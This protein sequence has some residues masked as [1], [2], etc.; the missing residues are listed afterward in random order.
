MSTNDMLNM[1]E[2]PKDEKDHL[3]TNDPFYVNTDLIPQASF[4]EQESELQDMGLSVFNQ[5]DFEQGIMDQV[6]RALAKEEENRFRKILQKELKTIGD[7]IVLAKADLKHV[8]EVVDR[9]E[10]TPGHA[11]DRQIQSLQKQKENKLKQIKTLK[12]RHENVTKKLDMLIKGVQIVNRTNN[13]GNTTL[14]EAFSVGTRPESEKERLIRSGEMTPF[15]TVVKPS[16]SAS[17][18]KDVGVPQM[19]AFEKTL[20][21]KQSTSQSTQKRF[22]KY[23]KKKSLE[24]IVRPGLS[25]PP[26]DSEAV[27]QDQSHRQALRRGCKKKTNSESQKEHILSDDLT[28]EED[29]SLNH[30]DEDDY[31]PSEEESSEENFSEKSADEADILSTHKRKRRSSSHSAVRKKPRPLPKYKKNEDDDLAHPKVKRD[32]SIKRE[33]DDADPDYYQKRLRKLQKQEKKGEQRDTDDRDKESEFDGGFHVPQKLWTKLFPYQKTGVRWLWEL[34]CQQ[35]GGI[36][37]D[38]MGLGKTIQTI[39]FLAAL[40]TS[41]LK[42]VNFPYK[43]LGPTI[44][45]CPTTVMHQWLKE[46]HKWW[47]EFRVAILHSSGSFSGSESDLVRSIAKS[48]GILITSYNTLVVHQE[49][50]LRFNWHYVILDEGHKIRNPDAKVTIC[51]KQFRT[52]HRIILSGSPIQN[53]LKELWSLFDFVFPGKL[54]TLP[55]FMQHFSIPIVQGGYSNATQIQVETAYRCACVLRDT[56][57]PYLI[58]RMKADVKKGLDLPNKNEQVLFCRLTDEQREV[59]QEYLASRQ[60]QDILQG[61][62]Q[63][64]VGLITLRKICNHPDLSTGGPQVFKSQSALSDPE[65]QFGYHKRS[66]KMIVVEAL[67]RL[68]YKQQHRVLLFTQSKSM[69]NIL[70]KFVQ[71]QGYSYLIMDGGTSISARQPLITQYNNDPSIYLFLLTTRVG[72]LGVNLTGADR[73]IIY[74]PDWNP[75]TDVQA[76]ERAWR[77]GQTRQVTIYRLLTSGTIEE[78]IYHR[79]VIQIFKQFLTN[80]ILK[81]PKQRRLFKSQDMMELFTLGS[82]DNIEGTET[83]ALFAG[84]GSDVKIPKRRNRNRFDEL[85]EKKEKDKALENVKQSVCEDEDMG[86]DIDELERMKELA[87]QLSRQMENEKKNKLKMADAAKISLDNVQVANVNSSSKATWSSDGSVLNDEH[88]PSSKGCDIN[89]ET[90]VKVMEIEVNSEVNN[91]NSNQPQ[92]VD[93]HQLEQSTEPQWDSIINKSHH[94]L[95]QPTLTQ[96]DNTNKSHQLLD[97]PTLTQSDNT[98]KSH[99]L[100]DQPTLIQSDNT[101]K[102]NQLLDQPTLTQSDNT[103]KSLLW[104]RNGKLWSI[105]KTKK[106]ISTDDQDVHLNNKEKS[107]ANDN[108]SLSTHRPV[109]KNIVNNIKYSDGELN[110]K[111]GKRRKEKKKRRH[112]ARFEGERI[113]HLVK[114]CPL[115]QKTESVDQPNASKEH[116]PHEDHHEDDYVL[117]QLFKKTG[118]QGA[119]KHDKIMDSGRPD[120]AIVEAEAEKVAREA[121]AALKRSR[122]LCSSALSGL[123][124]WTG[125]SGGLAKPRFGQKKNSLLATKTRTEISSA[126]ASSSLENQSNVKETKDKNKLFD[127]SISGNVSLLSRN[128]TLT[129]NDLLS[130]IKSRKRISTIA[131]AEDDDFLR[132]DQPQA[133]DRKDEELLEDIRNYVAFMG[134]VNGQATTDEIVLNF[135]KRLPK[136]DAPKFKAMLNQ[137]CDFHGGLWKLKSEFR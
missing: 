23:L 35:A 6:D 131:V 60:C 62:F 48:Q 3:F 119:M 21:A 89:S 103:S 74:D 41:R 83:S 12:I 24:T 44:I 1:E 112:D 46:C 54:G 121:A 43:G 4:A 92:P 9:L 40:K 68:W 10:S 75:S 109:K 93:S 88:Y 137:I 95:D 122:Q 8:N 64:F 49:L 129:S 106:S 61:K 78:K 33:R 114:H 128:E 90:E 84:T 15:G 31:V 79:L 66:G 135:G 29:E 87:K 28:G 53:N 19:S 13:D 27:L 42:N 127:G 100:L 108:S 73:V 16:L 72:G 58:R 18:Q 65:F 39:A 124:N 125:Q 69:L 11:S 85:L 2:Q 7:D 117:R 22:N 116:P 91:C 45:V 120:Y 51:C 107:Q 80:R 71:E 111:E 14:D 94:L 76:R 99:Q 123:P 5:N 96:S 52:P 25:L 126:Q 30:I 104:Q 36:I 57:N 67:L 56:I 97:Q 86:L 50:V 63:V 133:I 130:R 105:P 17:K 38:E 81:D 136:S 34:H 82:Q 118:I 110:P 115:P 132:P 77:I 102:S 59:Y 37:G 20:M 70:E 32:Y 26:D 98:S 47:P 101:N 55:D 134:N 113:P